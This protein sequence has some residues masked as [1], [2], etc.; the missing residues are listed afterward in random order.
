ML[1]R[2]L[3]VIPFALLHLALLLPI[4]I[5]N[6][7]AGLVCDTMVQIAPSYATQGMS[8]YREWLRG[9]CANCTAVTECNDRGAAKPIPLTDAQL[10]SHARRRGFCPYSSTLEHPLV[11]WKVGGLTPSAGPMSSLRGVLSSEQ[12]EAF[13]DFVE[14]GGLDI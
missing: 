9:G 10:A 3:A 2:R 1:L 5:F 6:R 8:D 12:V 13:I 14:A 4:T 7:L 11:K